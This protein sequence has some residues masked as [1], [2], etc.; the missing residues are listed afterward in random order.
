MLLQTVLATEKYLTMFLKLFC[1]SRNFLLQL[2]EQTLV[3]NCFSGTG[4]V[5]KGQEERDDDGDLFVVCFALRTT[6]RSSVNKMAVPPAGPTRCL[7]SF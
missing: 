1:N 2:K 5:I 4:H 3:F 6:H 7:A